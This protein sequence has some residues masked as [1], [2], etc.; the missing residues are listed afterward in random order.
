MWTEADHP[1]SQWLGKVLE[2]FEYDEFASQTLG[3]HGCS[4][5]KVQRLEGTSRDKFQIS[6]EPKSS[7]SQ[8]SYVLGVVLSSSLLQ[9]AIRI[10]YHKGV[11]IA[12]RTLRLTKANPQNQ[13]E[14]AECLCHRGR[15]RHF[16]SHFQTANS[17]SQNKLSLGCT[18]H[19]RNLG[20]QRV[21]NEY[22]QQKMD[23]AK[24]SLLNLLILLLN[25]LEW[26]L[27]N[28]LILF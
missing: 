7:K 28:L 13:W 10:S 16:E 8:R 21:A 23:Q 20:S 18:Q 17:L 25:S 3:P 6:N 11:K 2:L 26:I 22:K 27:L 1:P 14:C 9:Q 12:I 15:Q 24:A 19:R 5:S 4:H